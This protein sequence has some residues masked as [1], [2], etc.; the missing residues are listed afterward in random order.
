M[1]VTLIKALI[2]L[3]PTGALT[4]WLALRFLRRK[5][6]FHFLQALGAGCFVIVALTHV[7]EALRWFP[8]M[9]WGEAHSLGHYLDL[10]SAVAGLTLF[11]IG[12][13]M[14]SLKR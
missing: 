11:P 1:N 12:Y 10:C 3:L 5:T 8:R 13:F 14:Q 4:I 7:C 6:L 2:A 9:H